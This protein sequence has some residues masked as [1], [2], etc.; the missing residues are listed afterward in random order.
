VREKQLNVRVNSEEAGR[1]KAVAAHYGLNCAALFRMLLK[2]EADAI[3]K[4]PK[5]KPPGGEQAT[6]RL[7]EQEGRTVEAGR[8]SSRWHRRC[9]RS[10]AK[11][12]ATSRRVT[13][14]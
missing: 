13:L 5:R 11:R 14:Q 8:R 2:R 9:H 12:H 7:G 6:G 10:S 3:G 1:F 4:R